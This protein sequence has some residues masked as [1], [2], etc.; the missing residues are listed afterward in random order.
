MFEAWRPLTKQLNGSIPPMEK[1][2]NLPTRGK[3]SL[4]G[5]YREYVEEENVLKPQT[6][7]PK[8]KLTGFQLKLAA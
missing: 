1:R 5:V 3:S 8:N 2:L 4:I 6:K 7:Q